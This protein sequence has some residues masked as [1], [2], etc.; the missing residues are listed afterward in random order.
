MTLANT[1]ATVKAN[2]RHKDYPD[3]PEKT[4]KHERII[5]PVITGITG[6]YSTS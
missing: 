5:M 3:P 2:S 4:D 1:S 6:L